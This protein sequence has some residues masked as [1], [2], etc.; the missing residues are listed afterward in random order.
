M[1]LRWKLFSILV[2]I[3]TLSLVLAAVFITGSTYKQSLRSEI[4]RGLREQQSMAFSMRVYLLSSQA[5]A[6]SQFRI[7]DYGVPLVDMFS[8][9][10]IYLGA[11]DSTK[12]LL[13]ASRGCQLVKKWDNRVT[14]P[15]RTYIL[16]HSTGHYFLLIFD[17]LQV[18][19]QSM[20]LIVARDIS[21]LE[22]QR[23]AS[24]LLFVRFGVAGLLLVGIAGAFVSRWLVGPVEKLGVAAHRIASGF[25]N[26]RVTIAGHDE[27]S[28]LASHFNTM[29]REIQK[30]VEELH[31]ESKRKQMFV[32]NLGHEL[33]TPLT[34]IIGYSDILRQMKYD[35]DKMTAGLGF[36][37]A[38]G[39]RMLRLADT[40]MLLTNLRG[41][42]L[43][44]E[45]ISSKL[46]LEEVAQVLAFK[47]ADRGITLR[48][49]DAQIDFAGNRDL[50]KELLI[51]LG[52]NAINASPDGSEVVLGIRDGEEWSLF[53]QD[54]GQGMEEEELQHIT[55]PFYRTDKSRSRRRG[56][57]GLGLS[58]GAEIARLHNAA[59][60][61]TSIP[62]QGTLAEIVFRKS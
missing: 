52:D 60:Q 15:T 11:F 50:L 31:Q 58:L 48:T 16:R 47:A 55:E 41:E 56:G 59:L 10:G 6:A 12:R 5:I 35:E 53:V 26:E 33:R 28:E 3:Y 27:L 38:E 24:Y 54:Q 40:L 18:A 43:E 1:K 30:N 44:I 22:A 37:H 2:I 25:Y 29:A 8:G 42:D 32:D 9:K 17:H 45:P 21:F 51:N 49:I 7:A 57:T 62:G 34:A 46:L 14:S 13:N 39:R 4:D 19:E 61:F 23:R 36:I 20:F